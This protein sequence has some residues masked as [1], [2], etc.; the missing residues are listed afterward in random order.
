[1]LPLPH[2]VDLFTYVFACLGRSSLTLCICRTVFSFG[3]AIARRRY[4]TS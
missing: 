3:I 4:D 1:M 2:V